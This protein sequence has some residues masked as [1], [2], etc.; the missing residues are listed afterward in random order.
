[1]QD[2]ITTWLFLTLVSLGACQPEVTW[3]RQNYTGMFE[4]EYV[5]K[6]VWLPFSARVGSSLLMRRRRDPWFPGRRFVLRR[7]SVQDPWPT[8]LPEGHEPLGTSG[9]GTGRPQTRCYRTL[10]RGSAKAKLKKIYECL[11]KSLVNQ[12]L[13]VKLLSKIIVD[14]YYYKV[15]I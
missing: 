3:K 5:W 2:K 8:N 14:M 11:A 12:S 1:M 10:L 15:R 7:V 4:K 9:W 6:V 13:K